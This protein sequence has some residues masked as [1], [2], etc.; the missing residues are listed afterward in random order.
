[1]SSSSSM[2]MRS[3]RARLWMRRSVGLHR[4]WR[5][6]R[7]AGMPRI[8]S[9]VL[10]TRSPV[11]LATSA[12]SLPSTRT[13]HVDTFNATDSASAWTSPFPPRL[14][15]AV[16]QHMPKLVYVGFHPRGGLHILRHRY[17]LGRVIDE[18]VRAVDRPLVFDELQLEPCRIDLSGEAV[19]EPDRR[20]PFE[21]H[22]PVHGSAASREEATDEALGR[23]VNPREGRRAWRWKLNQGADCAVIRV[24]PPTAA[25]FR[26]T[27]HWVRRIAPDH[28]R[29]FSSRRRSGVVRWKGML[30]TITGS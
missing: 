21:G 3:N 29:V 4:L 19:R 30:P 17:R 22:D 5:S 6:P 2:M 24:L 28:V 9:A 1:M 10:R 12:G 13:A 11:A 25:C 27:S 18:P 23:G 7:S 26:A 16:H 15:R 8:P 20:F 14:V